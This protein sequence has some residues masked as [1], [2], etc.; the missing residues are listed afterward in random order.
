M[1]FLVFLKVVQSSINKSHIN[2]QKAAPHDVTTRNTTPWKLLHH[3]SLLEVSNFLWSPNVKS[4]KILNP[5]HL[6]AKIVLILI[7]Q[8]NYVKYLVL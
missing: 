5:L 6:S 4:V 7:K 3:L 1:S 8:K 2:V